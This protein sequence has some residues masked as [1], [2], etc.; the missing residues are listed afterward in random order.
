M[1][2]SGWIALTL[3]ALVVAALAALSCGGDDEAKPPPAADAA[4]DVSGDADPCSTFTSS[5]KPCALPRTRMCFAQCSTG[6]CF[7]D[8][9][10]WACVTDLSCLRDANLL[11][12]VNQ[13]PEDASASDA[14]ADAPADATDAG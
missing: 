3:A 8:N 5:G 10:T 12:D 11:E 2:R 6:G 13:P 1:T 14:A 9:G 4:L 7:C